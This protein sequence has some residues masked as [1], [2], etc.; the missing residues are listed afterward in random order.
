MSGTVSDYM[1]YRLTQWGV[2]R[3]YGYPGDGINGILGALGRTREFQPIQTRARLHPLQR[4]LQRA[5]RGAPGQGPPARQQAR[6]FAQALLEGDENARGIIV[7]SLE[8]MVEQ[9]KPKKG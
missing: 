6:H 5:A 2:R 4:G 7:Q 1:L 9:F 8:G 3:I